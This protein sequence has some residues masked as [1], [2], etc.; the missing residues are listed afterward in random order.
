MIESRPN[1]ARA[2]AEALQLLSRL[3]FTQPPVNP[4]LVALGLDLRVNFVT[5]SETERNV[6]GFFDFEEDA[7]FVN[8]D[9]VPLRQTFT[10]AHE[11]GHKVLHET[12]L[13]SADYK[14]LMRDSMD[15]SG[16][17]HE[18]EADAFAANLLMPRFMLD[19]YVNDC[20]PQQLAR[21]FAVSLPAMKARL[22]YLYG[23]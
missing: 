1:Y 15:K 3:G 10:I 21:L 8:A 11:I 2:E 16:D 23:I 19:N 6:S 13:K 18:R 20:S 17:C 22:S 7:I 12:W 14:V 4:R 9:E 5:F